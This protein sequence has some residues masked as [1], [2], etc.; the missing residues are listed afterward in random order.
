MIDIIV[1][2]E[3]DGTKAVVRFWYHQVGDLVTADEPLV[4]LETDKVAQEVTAPCTG[5]LAEIMVQP[6]EDAMPGAI[7]GRIRPA[8]AIAA[9]AAPAARSEHGPAAAGSPPPLS[10]SVRQALEQHGL[11]ASEVEGTGRDGR[12]SLADVEQAAARRV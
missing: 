10:A 2:V 3:Q 7:L 5:V 11:R 1:P 6:D 9:E 12:I 4:E 8:I